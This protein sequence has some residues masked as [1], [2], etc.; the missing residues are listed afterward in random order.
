[1][2]GTPTK[3]LTDSAIFHLV[4]T[5]NVKAADGRKK[6]CACD[7]STRSGH[8][9]ILDETYAN[10]VDQTSAR[11]F[12]SVAAG[13]NMLVFGADVSN[14]FAEA[15]P[16]KQGFFIRPD[17]AFHEWWTLHKH[18]PPLPPDF[19]IPINSAMQGHP[20][21]PRLWE[22]HTDKILRTIGL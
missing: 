18:R 12:Y 5:Y 13:E 9:R 6:A 15:P 10:C 1:M 8:V 2:F 7:G 20:E 22:K 21:S 4:W 14:A 17:R 19:I 3:A 16:P 11:L